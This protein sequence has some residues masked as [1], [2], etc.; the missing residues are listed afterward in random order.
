MMCV[1]TE[2]E[3]IFLPIQVNDY[4]AVFVTPS[5]FSTVLPFVKQTP[6]V[7][8]LVWKSWCAHLGIIICL[9]W[10]P[11]FGWPDFAMSE[12]KWSQHSQITY[13]KWILRSETETGVLVW[14]CCSV[15]LI[16]SFSSSAI[17]NWSTCHNVNQFEVIPEC[18]QCWVGYW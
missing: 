12:L 17:Q 4:V 10:I 8:F 6:G 13:W 2:E 15:N 18:Q 16:S 11:K 14:S 5:S 7:C 3:S 1:V 9:F